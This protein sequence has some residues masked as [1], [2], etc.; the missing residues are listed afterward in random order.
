MLRERGDQLLAPGC[1]K[2]TQKTSPT[3]CLARLVPLSVNYFGITG[4]SWLLLV[5]T[6]LDALPA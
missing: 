2:Q 6:L 4:P 5:F 3:S 1:E